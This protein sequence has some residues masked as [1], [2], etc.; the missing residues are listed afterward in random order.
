MVVRTST[1]TRLSGLTWLRFFE[2]GAW[3]PQGADSLFGA[4]AG[5]DL[6][7]FS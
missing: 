3:P 7:P 5:L 1:V 2:R 6:S 4:S